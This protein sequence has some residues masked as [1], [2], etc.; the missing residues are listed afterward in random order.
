[1]LYFFNNSI[2]DVGLTLL[3]CLSFGAFISAT[4]PV[5]VLAIYHDLHVDFRLFA[6]VFGES[7]MNDAVA[8]VLFST[9]EQMRE[10]DATAGNVLFAMCVV[11]TFCGG[12]SP[13]ICFR[14]CCPPTPQPPTPARAADA[15]TAS[16]LRGGG[17]GS[18]SLSSS[19]VRSP[20]VASLAWS[21]QS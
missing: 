15:Y 21:R 17:A 9:L 16:S 13:C 8:L 14:R 11:D 6:I 3:D 1:M 20:A 7:V 10:Q 19:W 18:S 5:T 12:K 4:D 2:Q